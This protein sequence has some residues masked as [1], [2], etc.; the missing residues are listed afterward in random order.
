MNETGPM[1]SGGT[2]SPQSTYY[3]PTTESPVLATTTT[4]W[5]LHCLVVQ[6]YPATEDK[7]GLVVSSARRAKADV[8]RDHGIG[9]EV[10][11]TLFGW[12]DDRL[13]QV[14][15]ATADVMRTSPEHRTLVFSRAGFVFRRGFACDELTLLSEGW[16]ATTSAP[17]QELPQRFADG[18][19]DV[20]ECLVVTH[21][22]QDAQV[23]VAASPYTYGLARRVSF[24]PQVYL[25]R[26]S[27]DGLPFIGMFQMALG[28]DADL[29]G[30][31]PML[32]DQLAEQGLVVIDLSDA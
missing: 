8:V 21:V 29:V 11:T 12:R 19:R 4:P 7:I 23:T 1:G 32:L 6:M 24:D 28:A 14:A 17:R 20:H 5:P 18:D 2:T 3:L 30:S 15:Q 31:A 22:D 16:C 13:I 27:T 9:E 10:R 26:D 25:Y